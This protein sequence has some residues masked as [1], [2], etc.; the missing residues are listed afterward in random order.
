MESLAISNGP[1]FVRK[2]DSKTTQKFEL[3]KIE[4]AIQAAWDAVRPGREA[5]IDARKIATNVVIKFA[6]IEVADVERIQTEVGY[7]LMDIDK[8]VAEAFIEYRT[9]RAAAREARRSPDAKALADYIH[10]AKYARYI[11]E[12]NR[13][14][15]FEETVDRVRVMHLKKFPQVR[16]EINWAFDRVL[17]KRAFPS[18]R[19]MQFGGEAIEKVNCRQYN[20]SFMH[21][22]R[23]EAFSETLYLLLCGSGVGFSVQ[24]HHVDKLPKLAVV[25]VTKPETFKVVHH[26]IDDSIEGWAN[27]L[28]ELIYGHVA[29]YYVEFDYSKIRPCGAPLKT[30][31]GRAPGHVGLKIALERIREILT[32]AGGRKL[33]PIEAYDVLCLAADAVLSGGI[34]RSAMIA[35][36]SPGNQEMLTSKVGDWYSK[37]PWRA[38]SNNSVVL[39]RG[40]VALDDFSNIIQAT[41]QWGE[42]GFL[43]VDNIEYG[44]NPCVE[45]GLDPTLHVDASNVERLRERG[46]NV[47]IGDK[48]SGVAFCNLTEINAAKFTS[49]EDFKIGARAA[50]I[51]GTLQAAY[52]DFPY[53]GIVSEEI[54]RRDALLG[55]SMTGMMDAPEI[56][57][58]P[59]YQRIVAEYVLEVNAEIAA[60]IGVNP[61]ARATAVKPAGTSSLAFGGVA[62]GHHAHHARRQFRRVTAN[63]MEPV[64]QYFKMINE[65]MC[66]RKPN[67][68]YAIEFVIEA[69][70]GAIVKDDLTAVEFMEMV[71]STQINWVVTGTGRPEVSPGLK[72]NVSNTIQVREHEWKEVTEYLFNN[73]QYFTGVSLLPATADKAYPF[74]PNESI[75]T[76]ADENRWNQ[77]V[78]LYKP[79]DYS[80]MIELEDGTALKAEAA[81]AGGACMIG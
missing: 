35:L 68:D 70:P 8:E 33:T 58:N 10:A 20:C 30:S 55:V 27:A 2:R 29:G 9:R 14:E 57:C 15:V 56:A 69:P 43:F 34:R 3:K 80:L 24:D 4:R 26:S 77:I 62:S 51:L 61:A 19:A 32:T 47:N 79:V 72:H 18:M 59:E 49:L 65:H 71:K 48:L 25:D 73:Q 50:T 38:N 6:G 53:L 22:N 52:T 66:V 37:H 76:E 54:A 11:P 1:L 46:L 31:G 40:E 12:L 42:P 36:F 67:G 21:I 41:R 44:A 60:K 45:I 23:L 74:A 16:E 39:K 13:R 28:K 75:S 63:V 81:C 5:E 17:E 78:E 64:F 7:A